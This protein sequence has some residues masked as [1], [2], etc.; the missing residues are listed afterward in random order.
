M[1]GG[2]TLPLSESAEEEVKPDLPV[3][4]GVS[5]SSPDEAIAPSSPSPP[6]DHR[7][8]QELLQRIVVE[9]HISLEDVHNT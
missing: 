4:M 7:Q 6:D 8:Y 9:V 3:S 5:S 1:H 2:I